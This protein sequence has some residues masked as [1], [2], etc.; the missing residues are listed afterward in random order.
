MSFRRWFMTGLLVVLSCTFL[1]STAVLVVLKE[2]EEGLRLT[3]EEALSQSRSANQTLEQEIQRHKVKSARLEL[4][5]LALERTNRWT[6]VRVKGLEKKLDHLQKEI[7]R[8]RFEK[9]TLTQERNLL[10][11]KLFVALGEKKNLKTQLTKTLAQVPQEVD[12]G[13]IIISANPPLEGK[14]LVA[15][16]KFQFVVIDLGREKELDMGALLSVYR[17]D[18]LIGRI[19]VEQVRETVAACRILPEWTS[20]EIQENDLV[21]E[22]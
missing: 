1:A 2:R 4:E 8:E 13:Q 21:K 6:L 15:N 12:L 10:S 17:Q 7:T 5:F 20:Q 22:L 14:I 9:Q 19:Q 16:P 11:N 3:A 18:Q